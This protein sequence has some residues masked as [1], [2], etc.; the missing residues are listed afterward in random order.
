MTMV[1][2]ISFARERKNAPIDYVP[3]LKDSN[4]SKP[5]QLNDKIW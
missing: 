3:E 1:I 2:V 4:S 5:Y